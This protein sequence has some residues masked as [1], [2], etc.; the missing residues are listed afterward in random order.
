VFTRILDG[1]EPDIPVKI[2]KAARQTKGVDHVSEV[3]VRWLGHRMH[4]ELNVTVGKGLTVEKGHDIA[5]AVRH[6]LLHHL[7]FLSEVTVHVDPPNAS[8]EKHHHIPKHE[9]GHEAAHSH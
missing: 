1:V 8:G 9:H 3:R 6:D 7:Q 5:C 2:T 4:A